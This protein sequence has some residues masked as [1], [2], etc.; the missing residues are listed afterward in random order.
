MNYVTTPTEQDIEF[1]AKKLIKPSCKLWKNQIKAMFLKKF[2]SSRRNLFV[3]ILIFI[4]PFLFTM[5]ALRPQNN[6]SEDQIIPPPLLITTNSYEELNILLE[7]RQSIDNGWYEN[8]F[9]EKIIILNI[10]IHLFKAVRSIRRI[11]QPKKRENIK[12]WDRYGKYYIKF[13][14][15]NF[16]KISAWFTK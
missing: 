16:N 2:Y 10:G 5:I 1:Q 8:N 12:C 9:S 13:G 7:K 15:E 11:R 4:I 14:K 3:L 6:I